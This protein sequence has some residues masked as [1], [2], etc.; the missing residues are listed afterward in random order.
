LSGNV[1]EWT[2][3][4]FIR[5]SLDASGKPA[6]ASTANCG[7]RVVEDGFQAVWRKQG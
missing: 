5:Q 1:W 4:C 3:S 2:N 7:V 6:G